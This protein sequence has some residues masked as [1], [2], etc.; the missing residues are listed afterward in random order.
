MMTPT[1]ADL[2]DLMVELGVAKIT[3]TK[4][5]CVAVDAIYAIPQITFQKLRWL[6]TGALF[7][8]TWAK[9]RKE[10]LWADWVRHFVELECSI[11]EACTKAAEIFRGTLA[12]A[13]PDRIRQVYFRIERE[14]RASAR[15]SV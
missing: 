1:A 3:P 2:L 14:R 9:Q 8:T 15:R 12:A 4:E 13:G 10:Q 5:P 7:R 6:I 11:E